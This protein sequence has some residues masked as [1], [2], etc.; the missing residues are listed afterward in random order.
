[1]AKLLKGK[2][3]S[4]NIIQHCAAK[5]SEIIT[6]GG[7]APQLAVV[8]V[9]YDS[10]NDSYLKGIRKKSADAGVLY[11]HIELE[12]DI[13][14][15]DLLTVI[16][17]LNNDDKINGILLLRPFPKNSS[18]DEFE[19]CEAIAP[20]KDVDAARISSLS[21]TY[22]NIGG[23]IPCTAEACIKILNH[24]G[25]EIAGKQAVVIGR[26]LIVGKPVANILQNLNATVTICHSQTHDIAKI[27][28][29]ADI[30]VVAT[31]TAKK[32]SAKYFK[33]G[34]VVIDAGINWDETTAKLCGDVDFDSV[35]PIV[36]AITPVP[37]G[38]GTVTS[39]VL[40]EHTIFN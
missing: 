32:F 7:L 9:D 15:T 12:Q 20:E 25:I 26:S 36:D 3:V 27:S 23:Y 34:Q 2:D 19:A 21:S 33:K 13:N 22:L 14:Q 16:N 24:Y 5:V 30:V 17:D 18:L 1:M 8:S 28:K 40:I 35:E 4:N 29:Q 10:S 31:G 11:Q 37:G 38:V 39:S 6:N